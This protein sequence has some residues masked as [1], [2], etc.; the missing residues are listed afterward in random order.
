ML[1]M[2][3]IP[4]GHVPYNHCNMSYDAVSNYKGDIIIFKGQFVWRVN[5][6]GPKRGAPKLIRDHWKTLPANLTKVDAVHEY[7]NGHVKIFIGKHFY[8][9][10]GERLLKA[11]F[12]RDLGISEE[13]EKIQLSI[14]VRH[15]SH[16]SASQ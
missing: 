7:D 5:E 6:N 9:F 12:L 4:I 2:D 13:I 11:G 1:G 10:D 8:D 15:Q 14:S 3:P 16:K